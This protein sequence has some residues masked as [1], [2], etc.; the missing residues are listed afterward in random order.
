M[1]LSRSP[2]ISLEDQILS[3]S[4]ILDEVGAYIYTKDL[5]G[6][7]T[8]ANAYVLKLFA[9]RLEDTIGKKDSDFF[10]LE[11]SN[12]LRAHDIQVMEHGETIEKEEINFIKATGERRIY[13][14]VKKPI[15]N[16]HG[17]IIGMCGIS[18][19]ITERKQIEQQLAE[20][21]QLLETILNNVDAFI[22]M[23]DSNRH[24]HYVNQ[25]TA[26]L[27]DH[28]VDAIIGK[29]DIEIMSEDFANHLWAMD[30][31]VFSSG[32]IHSGEESF[33][34]NDGNLR[35][36]WTVK[37]PYKLDESISTL[38]GFST[39]ITELHELKE[40]LRHQSNTCSLTN[41]YNRRY[42]FNELEREIS[43]VNRQ[44]GSL[45]L[46]VIDVDHFKTINDELGHP[47][48]DKVLQIISDVLANSVREIDT[49]AR[50]GG[51]EFAVIL[52][53]TNLK[54]GLILAERIRHQIH[55]HPLP[56]EM[57]FESPLSISIGIAEYDQSQ[58][59][60]EALYALADNMLYKAKQSG[61]NKVCHP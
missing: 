13:W 37:V 20:Q 44:N 10:D 61:R 21:N 24:F 39:D 1:S 46:L 31:K 26:D 60:L 27:F 35:H 18:T 59:T 34:D 43:R 40:Q 53:N 45:S 38:V 42:F 58:H 28:P 51:E 6:C 33:E 54:E 17:Q 7:Y 55:I 15:R 52:P 11:R 49:L 50:V 30:E 19:D 8:Y 23:K 41:L 48:G 3:L 57:N 9:T 25:K 22:Y 2:N 5:D 16:T 29:R 56:D 14:T 47:T 4:T 12:Q 36:Y 32:V